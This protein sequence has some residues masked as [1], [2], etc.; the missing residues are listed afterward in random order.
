M[1]D[2][3]GMINAAGDDTIKLEAVIRQKN[4]RIE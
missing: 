1:N 2:K 3:V 4:S